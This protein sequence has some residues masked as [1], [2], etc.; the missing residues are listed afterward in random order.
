MTE[1]LGV[2]LLDLEFG[3]PD[4]EIVDHRLV[5][6]G[7]REGAED[8]EDPEPRNQG[9]DHPSDIGEPAHRTKHRSG[10]GPA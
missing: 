1:H 3:D 2:E 7:D 5:A 8:L 10:A 6:D 9:E 4:A